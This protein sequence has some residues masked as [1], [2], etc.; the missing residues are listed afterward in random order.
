MCRH[1][2]TMRIFILLFLIFFPSLALAQTSVGKFTFVQG[3]VDVLRP[4]ASRAMPVKMG[5]AVFVGDIIRAKSKSRAEITFTD[6]NIVRVA[7]N[8][9]VEISEYMFEETKGKGILKLSRGKVQAIIQEKI[10]KRIATFGEANRFEIHTPTAIAGARGCNFI[11]SFQRNSSSV[12]VIEG[13]VFTYS[14]KFPDIVATVNTGYIATIPFDQPV[15]PA[16]PATDAEKK[17]Y[18][19]DFAPGG[20]GEKSETEDTVI[21]EATT[22]SAEPGEPEPGPESP[23]PMGAL[24]EI[25]QPPP[26]TETVGTD[27]TPPVINIAGPQSPTNS[28]DAIFDVTADETVTFTYRIDN[29]VVVVSPNTTEDHFGIPGLTDGD[30]IVTVTATDQA[31]NSSMANYTWTVD[32]TPPSVIT[33]P[34]TPTNLSTAS[35]GFNEPVT[36]TYSLDGG[37]S[38]SGTG[39]VIPLSGLSEEEHTII[40]TSATD[41]AGNPM[42]EPYDYSWTTDYGPPTV[43]LSGDPPDP[44]NQ[45]TAEFSVSSSEPVTYS[46]TLDGNPASSTSLSGISEGPH[47]FS[48]TATDLAGNSS[49]ESYSWTTDYTEPSISLTPVAASPQES[50]T[51]TI[52]IELESSEPPTYSYSLNG[53]E[54]TDIDPSFNIPNV[55]EGSN[56]LEVQ[57]TDDAGNLSSIEQLPFELSRYSISGSFYGCIAG[58]YGEVSGE[59]AGVRNQN[60][61]GWDMQMGGSG[62]YPNPTWTVSAGGRSSD[63]IESNDNGYW[64][65]I[66]NG[67][68]DYDSEILS[69]TSTFKY[70]S[71]DRIGTGKGI[72]SGN[73][74]EGESYEYTLKDVGLGTYTETP[75]DFSGDWGGDS[76]YRNEGGYFSYA[77]YDYGLIGL[78]LRPDNNYD[79]L[80]IG[81]YYDYGYGTAYLWN[82]DF[83]A[84]AVNGDGQ[85]RAIGFSG[86]IWKNGTMDGT[87]AA[88]YIDPNGNAG[89][90][91]GDVSGSYYPSIMMWM[92]EGTLTP[93]QRATGLNP[94]DLQTEWGSLDAHLLGD[95]NGS[96]S[97]EGWTG[98]GE[99]S[100]YGNTLFFV[101]D[102]ESLPWGI[103]NLKLGSGNTFSDKPEGTAD[104]S[105]MIGGQGTFGYEDDNGYWLAKVEGTW[106]D[107]GEIRGDLINGKYLTPTQMGAI[108]GPFFGINC[109]SKV[110]ETWIGE[111]IGTWSGEALGFGGII[112]S[113]LFQWDQDFWL[114]VDGGLTG[115]MGVAEIEGLP[116]F[117]SLGTY[118]S[119]YETNNLYDGALWGVDIVDST[120][121][122][123]ALL[124]ITGGIVLND[125]LEGGLLAIYLKPDGEGYETGYIH[126][127]NINGSLYPGLGMYELG[128]NLISVSM[129]TTSILPDNLNWDSIYGD[130]PSLHLVKG[131]G[132]IEGDLTGEIVSQNINIADQNWGAWW[133]SSVS[134]Y[135]EDLSIPSSWTAYAEGESYDMDWN[136]AGIWGS[137]AIGSRIDTGNKL[138]GETTGYFADISSIPI[139]GVSVGETLGTFDPNVYTWQAI[140]MGEWLET[141]KFLQMAANE[142]GRGKL[143]QLNIPCVEVGRATLTGS[144]NNFSNLNMTDTIFFAPNSGAKPTIWATGNVNGI[145]SSAPTINTPIGLSGGGLNADFT[146]KQ[147]NA[148]TGKWLSSINGTGGFNGS[149]S[150]QGAGAGTGATS[151]SG[152]ISGSAAGIAR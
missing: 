38:T 90:L 19:G 14:L 119:D 23:E 50:T 110:L 67:S 71:L 13:A 128:G 135:S 49:T 137:Q 117:L 7:P 108:G 3:R 77:G 44:S 72:L 130:S 79:L 6:G 129:G 150:F 96:G 17:M 133:A 103:Y 142:A 2:R 97:I 76:L 89:Y 45:D 12:F 87:A 66:A 25:V 54:W 61:G 31:G 136:T 86:G 29:T 37:T 138:I 141:N 134:Y 53:G 84:D 70:L 106:T 143:Q 22:G 109:H 144:G 145:Y 52:S 47:T 118:N 63:N 56:I 11:V 24:T 51:A 149:T 9:R 5:D 21:S 115:L 113:G 116:S 123:G 98:Y 85:G 35:F 18:E 20:S 4:P 59:I 1:L 95:F 92:S 33:A 124:G 140:Q 102:S 126:S 80:A 151:G 10:A 107:D 43:T 75:L 120:P 42:T 28:P 58:V 41:L 30:H 127:D 81:E 114:V 132:T 57:T 122:N 148:D 83:Y 74:Y 152:T 104:W 64:L 112:N 26:I 46:Y 82:S 105:A 8:T 101:K 93:T 32:T 34:P 40:V 55:P 139:T 121:D 27:T 73:Y 62:G 48:V 100:A 39:S 88:L 91:T 99:T 78:A 65:L 69:G 147:W 15:Q 68:T 60:W 94:E 16:R 36:Y 131:Y 125:N 111:S 146:F